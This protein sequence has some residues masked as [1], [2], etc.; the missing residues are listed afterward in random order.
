M[1]RFGDNDLYHSNMM[2]IL[3]DTFDCPLDVTILLKGSY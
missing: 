3:R 1:V 2:G